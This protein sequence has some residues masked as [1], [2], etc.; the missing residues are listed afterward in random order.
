MTVALGELADAIFLGIVV[1]NAAIGSVQEIRAKLALE[2]LAALVA[3]RARVLRSGRPRLLGVEAVVVGDRILLEPGDQVVADGDVVSASALRDRRVDPDRRVC[4]GGTRG[5]RQP[6]LRLVRSRGRRRVRRNRRRRRE[7]RRAA[8]RRGARVSAPAVAVP[9]RAQPADRDADRARH[10]A[11][12]RPL[13]DALAA[14]HAFRRRPPRRRR[15]G[16][17][18]RPRGADPAREHRLPLRRPQALPP[19]GAYAAAQRDRVARVGRDR[20]LRQDRHAHRAAPARRRARPGAGRR[21]GR[22]RAGTERLRGRVPGPKRDARG[23]RGCLPGA[24]ESTPSPPCRSRAAGAGAPPSSER[25]R[26]CSARPTCSSS[27]TSRPRARAEAE[28]GR[29]VVALGVTDGADR[30]PR[31]RVGPAAAPA[32]A[33]ARRPCRGAAADRRARP[34]ATCATRASPSSSSP[35]TTRRPSRRSR[36]TSACPPAGRSTDASCRPSRTSCSG[37]LEQA[38][39][40]GRIAPEGKR[41]IVEVLRDAG[42]Y[43]AMVGDGV[44]DVPAL[45]ASRVAIAQ[46]GGSQMART[47]ADLVLVRGSFDAVPRLVAEGRQILRN[48]QRVS[49]IYATK[50]VFGALVVLTLGLS[51]LPYPF[52]PRQLSFASFFVTGVPPFF[53]AL[54]RELRPLADDR[55]PTGHA[56]L[57]AT[58]GLC[59]RRRRRHVLRARAT[60]CSTS[61][62]SPPAPSRSASSSW[63]PSTSSSRSRRPTAGGRAGSASCAWSSAVRLRL[64]PSQS[65]RCGSSSSSPCPD[66]AEIGLIALGVAP[67]GRRADAR[68]YPSGRAL[69]AEREPGGRP[70]PT[71]RSASGR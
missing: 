38:I 53:L 1:A 68:R 32:G 26:T 37:P 24:G 57:C 58:G 9:A 48:M 3:P 14:R 7:L 13:P 20:L 23:D 33:R 44:N 65:R 21:R 34:S 4:A 66:A 5:G 56:S 59:D 28:Q 27:A 71:R 62:C 45:K 22:A 17:Q 29:R 2:R 51:P 31:P 10:P 30:Q 11:L 25:A 50:C 35:A 19:R 54:A 18:P 16:D 43:V 70:A 47:V 42:R 64:R 61:T 52:L 46:G 15:R 60:R 40:V 67:R 36:A 49:K 6:P 63:P 8:R 55:L 69:R 41:R 12:R 39:V